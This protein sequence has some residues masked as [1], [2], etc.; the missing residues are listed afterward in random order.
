MHHKNDIRIIG[1]R[2]KERRENL[3]LSQAEL[4]RDANTSQSFVSRLE[5]ATLSDID[6]GDLIATSRALH[7]SPFDMCEGTSFESFLGDVS[8]PL[9]EK[10]VAFCPNPLCCT[11]T[12]RIGK[13]G[14][15]LVVWTSQ[16]EYQEAFFQQINFCGFCGEKLVKQCP[17]CDWRVSSAMESFCTRCGESLHKRPTDAEWQEI[18]KL[19]SQDQ[20][21]NEIPF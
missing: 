2:V 13:D 21:D 4:A 1:E 3:G 11:N 16:T 18:G 5:R 20:G 7:S 14:N 9:N 19:Y 8:D 15:P 12:V 6:F 10:F 17:S